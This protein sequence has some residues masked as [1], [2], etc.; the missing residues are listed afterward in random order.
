MRTVQLMEIAD[1]VESCKDCGVKIKEST[2]RKAL[3]IPQD[4]PEAVC[5]EGLKSETEGLMV[6]PL[7]REY[8]RVMAMGKGK[9]KR[10]KKKK[11]E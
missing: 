4:K 11:K 2:L 3:I 6:N 1:I 8:W 7:P 9:K 10:G 5:L